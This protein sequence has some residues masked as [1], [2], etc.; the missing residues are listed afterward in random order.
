[1]ALINPPA[2]LQQGSYPARTDRLVMKSIVP[3]PGVVDG[4]AVVQTSGVSMGVRVGAGR[5]FI[6]GTSTALQGMYNVVNDAFTTI[7][8][9]GSDATFSRYDLIVVQVRDADVSGSA[10]EAVF[11]AITG[12][13][14]SSPQVP[15]APAS[16]IVLARVLVAAGASTIANAAITDTRLF[17]SAS[18]GIVW[19]PDQAARLRL[20][21]PG[22]LSA[23]YAHQNDTGT[24]WKNSGTA[25][26][27]MDPMPDSGW[28]PVDF[29]GG[30]GTTGNPAVRKIGSMVFWKG[31]IFGGTLD[32][33]VA[34]IPVAYSPVTRYAGELRRA[35]SGIQVG[36]INISPS[37]VIDIRENNG[38]PTSPGYS[39]SQISY[40]AD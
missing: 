18:G 24:L 36:K 29:T 2:W 5:A 35:G 28:I 11:Q 31:E 26:V 10:N 7:P 19:V 32:V 15:A 6:E 25:W 40:L 1:M 14:S 22:S 13:P 12:T 9:A 27:S 3:N 33:T 30:W 23:L 38:S 20:G 37:G 4:L 39:L 17:T 34:N 8:L 21:N 16:S